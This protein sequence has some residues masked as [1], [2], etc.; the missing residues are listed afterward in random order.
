MGLLRLSSL[1][2]PK[3]VPKATS[4]AESSRR[5]VPAHRCLRCVCCLATSAP[6]RCGRA[7]TRA[8][9]SIRFGA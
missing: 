2:V 6:S 5:S 9:S 3:E 8:P 4:M 1:K 7:P